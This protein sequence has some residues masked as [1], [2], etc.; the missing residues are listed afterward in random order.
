MAIC[1]V[2]AYIKFFIEKL[3]LYK[4][5]AYIAILIL[6]ILSTIIE[7][8]MTINHSLDQ[9]LLSSLQVYTMLYNILILLIFANC[10]PSVLLIG[11]ATED[12][13]DWIDP[14]DMLNFDPSTN[15]K[16]KRNKVRTITSIRVYRK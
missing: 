7:S 1:F 3:D 11:K 6:N 8:D 15:T 5:L 9:S 2:V 16:I 4:N 10:I 12:R 13:S 14:N